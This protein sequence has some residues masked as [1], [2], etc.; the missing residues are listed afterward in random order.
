[1]RSLVKRGEGPETLIAPT[2]PPA[3]RMG[4]A[5]QLMPISAYMLSVA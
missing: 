3:E 1:M 4:T 5:T 2:T